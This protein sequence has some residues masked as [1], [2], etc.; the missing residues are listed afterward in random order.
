MDKNK[1]KGG[2]HNFIPK[3]LIIVIIFATGVWVGQNVALPFGD[4]AK[5]INLTNSD[6]PSYVDVDFAPFWDVWDQITN[7]HLNN[8]DIDPQKLLYG[9]IAGMVNAVGDP[10]SVFLDPDQNS[11]FLS[12]LA[13]TFEGVGIELGSRDG[14]LVV[15]APLE[16]TPAEAAGVRAGDKI[17]GIDR[18]D[19]SD[20]T[21]PE[22]VQKIR[23]KAG[24]K[25][26]LTLKRGDKDPFDV[27]II[28]GNIQVKSVRLT[29]E[30]N[31]QVIR[32]SRFGDNTRSEWDEVVNKILT[33]NSQKL[34]LDMRNNPGGRLDFA[35]YVAGEFL[36]TGSVVTIQEDAEGNRLPLK[37][38]R[39][40]R[41]QNVELIILINE[42]SASASEI[43]A[44]ALSENKGIKLVGAK[45]FGKG[46]VQ[47]VEDLNDGS[48]LHITTA[49]WLTPKGNWVNDGGIKPDI[50]VERTDEDYDSGQDP[51]LKK[52]LQLLK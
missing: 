1:Y 49:K 13:G 6:N 25:V 19:A 9:A 43:V 22:A 44:G 37:S 23:G 41:L 32:L 30:D 34:I 5:I 39:E 14:S 48:G 17:V 15:V 36:P 31:I 46:T 27:E 21:I 42:G 4:S 3:I 12:S 26:I 8:E 2:L 35:I 52:A 16:G 40:G 33:G 45:T 51:Q 50:E 28:R 11:E 7:K 24:T 47:Q 10:Y 29:T 20:T 38:E 18:E